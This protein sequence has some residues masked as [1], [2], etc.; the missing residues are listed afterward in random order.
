[1]ASKTDPVR[2]KKYTNRRLYNTETSAYVTLD[3]LASMVK[4]DKEFVVVDAKSGKDLTH[5]VL[6]QIIL[7]QEGKG[8]NLMPV[9]FLRQL[10]RFYGHGME[11]FVPS[12]LELSLDT[13][14]REQDRYKSALGDTFTGR[15][16]EAMQEQ[17]RRNFA[18][19]EK[20]MSVFSPFSGAGTTEPA[21][22]S[23]DEHADAA[24]PAVMNGKG[25]SSSAGSKASQAG[26][27]KNLDVLQDQIAAMQKQ[28]D[29]LAKRK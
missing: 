13:F 19:F 24:P 29:A 23:D 25:A 26:A 10:I 8:Q 6:T 16:L 18:M 3:D 9:N 1:M 14:S 15:S 12:Y 22:D 5:S 17:T 4:D 27:D 11:R 2:I 28:I 21:P 7:E 20:A